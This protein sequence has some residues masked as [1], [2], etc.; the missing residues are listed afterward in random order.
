MKGIFSTSRKV[1]KCTIKKHETHKMM[2]KHE[3]TELQAKTN[4]VATRSCLEKLIN[5]GHSR[6]RQGESGR[7]RSC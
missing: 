3:R 6:R 4:D 1:H 7:R 5:K 2:E